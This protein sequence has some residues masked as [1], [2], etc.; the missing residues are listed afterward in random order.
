MISS[1][2]VCQADRIYQSWMAQLN[3]IVGGSFS[4]RKIEKV[5][6][7]LAKRNKADSMANEGEP[8]VKYVRVCISQHPEL[9]TLLTSLETRLNE[10]EPFS[11]QLGALLSFTLI[12]SYPKSPWLRGLRRFGG[13]GVWLA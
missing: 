12:L 10:D 5:D 11:N 13:G 4:L 2:P 6:K 7:R 8:V 1:Q 3:S 9:L